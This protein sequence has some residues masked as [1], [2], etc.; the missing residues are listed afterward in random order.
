MIKKINDYQPDVLW[1]GLGLPKQENWILKN[2]DKLKI[3]VIV[4]VGAAFKFEAGVVSRAPGWLGSAGFEWLWRLFMEP[5]TTWKRVFFD[6]PT[7]IWLVFV[8]FIKSK[9]S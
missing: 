8:D 5:K 2:K 6:A 1:V 9:L 4:G 3:P 7:F